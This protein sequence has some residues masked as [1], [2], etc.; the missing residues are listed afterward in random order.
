MVAPILLAEPATQE[1]QVLG[2]SHFPMNQR[3][4]LCLTQADY[5]EEPMSAWPIEWLG[6]TDVYRKQRPAVQITDQASSMMRGL[7]LKNVEHGKE[8]VE[9]A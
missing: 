3:I 7:H 6:S 4:E 2:S 8:C 5:L 1:R 9:I